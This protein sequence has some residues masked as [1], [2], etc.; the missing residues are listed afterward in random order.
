MPEPATPTKVLIC[1]DADGFRLLL[2]SLFQDAG[3][4]VATCTTWREV[5]DAVDREQPDAVLLDLWMPTF[6]VEE[7]VRV[8]RVAPDALL[9]VVSSLDRT[10]VGETVEGIGGIDVVLSKRDPPGSIV[11]ELME[12]LSDSTRVTRAHGERRRRGRL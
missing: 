5:V 12:R 3:C 9:A 7:L 2:Q 10:D 6:D 4:E 11:A 1:D 8:R